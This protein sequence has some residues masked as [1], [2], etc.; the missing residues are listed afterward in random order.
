MQRL[1]CRH[2]RVGDISVLLGSLPNPCGQRSHYIVRGSGE[3]FHAMSRDL[4]SRVTSS[5]M[6]CH[7]TS[8][9]HVKWKPPVSS[10]W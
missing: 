10:L 2:W 1:G 4:P 7:V 8:S 6:Q 5:F 9:S 3:L